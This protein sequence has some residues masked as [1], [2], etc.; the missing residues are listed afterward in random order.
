MSRLID[1]I[2]EIFSY[3]RQ[4][5]ARTA[6]TMFGLIWGTMTI[7]I[8]LAFGAGVKKQMS[9]NMHGI[10]EGI[11]I[12]W[13]GRT[14]IPFEGYGRERTIRLNEDDIEL[15]RSEVREINRI[16]PEFSKWGSTIR[17]DDKINRPNITGIIPE[18][19]W[20]RNIMPEPGGRWLNDLDIKNKRRV[21]FI[22]N[23]LRDFLFGENADAI[24]EYV[25]IDQTPFM[26]IGVMI[27][28]T[29][30]S[31]YSSRDR[32]RA[33]IPYTV[34][35]SIFGNQYVN[36]FVYQIDD[37]TKSKT[38]QTKVYSILAK[39][40]KFDPADKE[41][42]GIWDTNE[43]EAFIFYFSLG[44]TIFLG[45]MGVVTLLVGGIGLA[46]IMYVVVKE[47]THEIGIR[48]SL[49]ARKRNIFFQLLLEAFIV[50]GLGAMIGFILALGIIA[51]ISAIPSPELREAVGLPQL[52]LTV[53]LAA[54]LILCTIGFLAGFFP[55]RRAANLNVI[56]CL[57]Y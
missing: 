12:V 16:S 10:G 14:S 50:I 57:R 45:I 55:A 20:M 23:R 54:T 32:D 53:A 39:K 17:V 56:D 15:I 24:G 13:P 38:V 31:S 7:I 42:L 1:Y 47:R 27:E 25:Y 43:M 28:K 2:L 46:N 29:Q 52:N 48:R 51:L 11:A 4:Y 6:M 40:F 3:L 34:H 18:Y 35:K 37:P 21:V 49:G 9:I 19:A 26:V 22:G 44:L 36:N 5:K 30:N 8:L 41:T 33:F